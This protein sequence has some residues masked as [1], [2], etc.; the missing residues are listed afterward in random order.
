MAPRVSCV[1][2]AGHPKRGR[3]CWAGLRK[4]YWRMPTQGPYRP[5]RGR[6]GIQ[7]QEQ[8]PKSLRSVSKVGGKLSF[9]TESDILG[10][11]LEVQSLLLRHRRLWTSTLDRSLQKAQI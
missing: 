4:T 5:P 3:G 7:Q 1:E 10:F 9:G 6:V 8:N 2:M 11:S